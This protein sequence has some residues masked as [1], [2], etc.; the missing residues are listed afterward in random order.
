MEKI[1]SEDME[2]KQSKPVIITVYWLDSD[3]RLQGSNPELSRKNKAFREA[4]NCW[5]SQDIVMER[6]KLD[7]ERAPEI[8]KV[9]RLVLISTCQ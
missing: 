5:S 2:M 1:D 7:I 4:Q 6:R 8:C 9:F 3:S